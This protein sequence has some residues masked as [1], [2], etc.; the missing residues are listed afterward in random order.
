MAMIDKPGLG[1]P[2][3]PTK[4][5]DWNVPKPKIKKWTDADLAK[6]AGSRGLASRFLPLLALMT[7]YQG[8]SA[9]DEKFGLSDMLAEMLMP[10]PD[11]PSSDMR[12]EDFYEGETEVAK[13]D[14]R[15]R[16]MQDFIQRMGF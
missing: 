7:G 16:R 4:G 11:M 10:E 6:R 3:V 13:K 12:T 2:T 8:G 15:M 14:M 1:V 9:L 5:I